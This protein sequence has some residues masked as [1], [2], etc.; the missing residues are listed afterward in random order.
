MAIGETIAD[1]PLLHPCPPLLGNQIDLHA[2][3]LLQLADQH[4]A[5]AQACVG[6][7]A[8]LRLRYGLC[9][10]FCGRAA[11]LSRRSFCRCGLRRR[12]GILV[13]AG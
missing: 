11:F 2:E 8:G 9:Y 1:S 7:F 13:Q 10:S 12:G 5:L 4:V 6:W 3:A